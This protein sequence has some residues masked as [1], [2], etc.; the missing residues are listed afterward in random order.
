MVLIATSQGPWSHHTDHFLGIKNIG[1]GVPVGGFEETWRALRLR[2]GHALRLCARYLLQSGQSLNPLRQIA[3]AFA[4]SSGDRRIFAAAAFAR[5]W[6]ALRAP[7]I[8][9]LTASK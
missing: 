1:F 8:T 2:S 5:I 6:A 9:T 7:A 3:S 4:S